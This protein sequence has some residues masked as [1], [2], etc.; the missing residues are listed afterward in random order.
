MNDTSCAPDLDDIGVID[1][2]LVFFVCYVDDV[3]ALDI[4]YQTS[5]VDG[6]SQ[7]FD[8]LFSALGVIELNLAGEE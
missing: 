3:H 8:E 5:C 2:P 7:I 6:S 1:G 4:S